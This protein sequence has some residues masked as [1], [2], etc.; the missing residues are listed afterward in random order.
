MN[1]L[2]YIHFLTINALLTFLI[3]IIW[4]TKNILR[5]HISVKYQY[6]ICCLY[7]VLLL[8]P[9]LSV[10]SYMLNFPDLFGGLDNDLNHITNYLSNSSSINVTNTIGWLQDFTISVNRPNPTFLNFT[11][12]SLWFLGMVITALVTF[13]GN[14]KIKRMLR[15]NQSVQSKEICTTFQECI[16]LLGIH[17]DVKL[18]ASSFIK[19]PLICGFINPRV[20]LPVP[21]IN[22]LSKNDLRN[23]FLHELQHYRQKDI[24][25]NY[26]MCILQ[27][28]Y[29]YNPLV[30]FVFKEMRMDREIA[31]DRSVLVILGHENLFEY[32]NTIINFADKM[33][34]LSDIA[35]VSDMGG[36]SKQIKKRIFKIASFQNESKWLK[37][38]S[39]FIIFFFGMVIL[40][41]SPLLSIRAAMN[42]SYSFMGN[43]SKYEDLSSYFNGYEG[44]IVLYDTK[45]DQYTIYNKKRCADRYSPDS[46][47]K[48]YSALFGLEAGVVTKDNSN[49]NWNGTKYPFEVW[50]K[51]Q[52][53]SS[54]IKNSV[55]WYFQDL[56]KKIGLNNLK[57]YFARI[58]YGNTDLSGGISE[59]WMESSLLISPFE[60][61]ELLRNFYTNKYGFKEENIQIVKDALFL[62]E[63]NTNSLFGKTGTGNVNGKNVN[64]W[65]IGYV[66][67][68]DNT[69]FFATNIQNDTDANSSAAVKITM[70][71]LKDKNIYGLE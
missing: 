62:S 13:I 2:F 43:N 45:T 65:F 6:Y 17:K 31:C 51:N 23:I 25:I 52:D 47:Y 18:Y 42:S 10:K 36:S 1:N 70:S 12:A 67:S 54:A 57:N 53:L 24:L 21:V 68:D 27:I 63:I 29:W 16:D 15:W 5:K 56:D 20:I 26:I 49:L 9:F 22:S 34:H 35:C 48:I 40:A 19:A 39:I 30:W 3:I 64:G 44:C 14:Y 66:E 55:S 33:M 60:Q 37:I 28:I 41:S 71:I 50:N 32:G 38:K 46:T 4:V 8:L 11:I 59:Y 61:V 69:Y 58:N 7:L